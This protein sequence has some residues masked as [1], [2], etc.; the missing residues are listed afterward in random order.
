MFLNTELSSGEKWQI[1]W[2]AWDMII[3]R[4]MENWWILGWLDEMHRINFLLSRN[5]WAG[6][7]LTVINSL[8]VLL[9]LFTKN[10]TFYMISCSWMYLFYIY[11]FYNVNI[12]KG[13]C[14]F[15]SCGLLFFSF[16][17]PTKFLLQK[18]PYGMQKCLVLVPEK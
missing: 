5:S 2:E 8:K 14:N 4:W 1:W 7:W 6:I 13:N 12:F 9:V 16:L 18:N 3:N 17:V 15:G 11:S 10:D